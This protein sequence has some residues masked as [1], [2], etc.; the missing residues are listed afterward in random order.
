MKLSETNTTAEILYLTA[1]KYN[2]YPAETITFHLDFKAATTK[3]I[4]LQVVWPKVVKIVSYQL[5]EGVP[6]LLP[7]VAEIDQDI[8][9]MVPLENYFEAEQD[10]HISVQA[11]INTFSINQYL[12]AKAELINLNSSTVLSTESVRITVFGKA[13]S[14]R[15]LPEIYDGD[16]FMSR[17]LML[18]ESFWNPINTQINQVEHYFDP[19]LTPETFIPWLASWVGLPIDDFLPLNRVRNL[20]NHALEIFQLRGTVK[21]LQIFLEIFTESHVFIT[22]HRS[23]NFVLGEQNRLGLERALGKENQPMTVTIQL[24]I[25]QAELTRSKLTSIMYNKKM[26]DIVRTMVPAHIMYDVRCEFQSE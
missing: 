1:E 7:T 23:D 9:M 15:Y 18:F 5:P 22:E 6:Q 19:Q 11:Q 3:G 10:Y 4:N 13:N 12:H 14:L 20:L 26:K 25:P 2:C 16:D 8:M 17:F 21:A 24:Q